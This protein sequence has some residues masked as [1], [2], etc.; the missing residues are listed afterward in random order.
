M[1]GVVIVTHGNLAKGFRSAAS[2]IV[3]T[4]NLPAIGLFP[5]HDLDYFE[6]EIRQAIETFKSESRDV[7]VFTDLM[8]G[9]PFNKVSMLMEELNFQ[10]FT[11]VSLPVLLES[12]VM[13]QTS[14]LEDVVSMLES[15]VSSTF[16]HVN[17]FLEEGE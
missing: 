7:L 14:T 5:G 17:K 12:L 13:R 3:G 1:F 11:G 8:Y 10:H 6:K 16:I 15:Y 4:N 9:T 2:M